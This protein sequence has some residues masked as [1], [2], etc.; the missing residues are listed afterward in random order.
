MHTLTEAFKK[1]MTA[2]ESYTASSSKPLIS[3]CRPATT[4]CIPAALH[5]IMS[6][7]RPV[8]TV[9]VVGLNCVILSDTLLVVLSCLCKVSQDMF[10]AITLKYLR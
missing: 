7:F 6:E 9:K 1:N 5:D 3:A 4:M 8:D 10:S 2:S